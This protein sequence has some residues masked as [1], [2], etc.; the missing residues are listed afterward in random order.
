M[1]S[2]ALLERPWL[3]LVI[4]I[5]IIMRVA[6]YPILIRRAPSTWLFMPLQQILA[7]LGPSKT[8]SSLFCYII[9]IEKNNAK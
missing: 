3:F 7:T 6:S 2:H 8:C 1:H 9:A 4:I 5:S